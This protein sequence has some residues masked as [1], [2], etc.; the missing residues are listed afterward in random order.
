MS[1]EY[2]PQL[3]TSEDVFTVQFP[4]TKFRDG[5]DQ[6]QIDDY[7]DEVVRVLSYY[8]ALNASP[9]AEV[10]LAYI[11]VRGVDVREVDFDY[12]RMRVG[13]DQDAVDD[14]LDQV[15]ATLE[16]Y[17]RAYGIPP[18]DQHYQ[19]LQVDGPA[20]EAEAAQQAAASGELP[21]DAQGAQD[22]QAADKTGDTPQITAGDDNTSAQYQTGYDSNALT[23]SATETGKLFPSVS[24]Y[25]SEPNNY[26]AS[27]DS[28]TEPRND[29]PEYSS[30][31]GTP[32][33]HPEAAGKTENNLVNA[34][35]TTPAPNPVGAGLAGEANPE[36]SET[37]P[38]NP[39]TP[40]NATGYNGTQAY[41]GYDQEYDTGYEPDSEP[42]SE[43]GDYAEQPQDETEYVNEDESDTGA[44]TDTE[45]PVEY[46]GETSPGSPGST[47]NP[48]AYAGNNTDSAGSDNYAYASESNQ[49]NPSQPQNEPDA[50]LSEA[51]LD[52]P[53][54]IDLTDETGETGETPQ[55]YPEYQNYSGYQPAETPQDAPGQS[56]ATGAE[57]ASPLGTMTP[58]AETPLATGGSEDSANPL[59]DAPAAPSAG[60]YPNYAEAP[61]TPYAAPADFTN[62]APAG[63][64][65]QSN[66][67]A[68]STEY[69]GMPPY[70]YD[71][72]LAYGY[73]QQSWNQSVDYSQYPGQAPYQPNGQETQ[74]AWEQIPAS[75]PNGETQTDNAWGN[76]PEN[77]DYAGTADSSGQGAY[78]GYPGQM[79]QP[80]ANGMP[81]QASGTP[82]TA[83]PSP[84]ANPDQPSGMPETGVPAGN[85]APAAGQDTTLDYGNTGG[86][87]A[88][89]TPV[90]YLSYPSYPATA[91]NSEYP[92]GTGEAGGNATPGF[93]QTPAVSSQ[94]L[95]STAVP[96]EA[97]GVPE[98]MPASGL[99]ADAFRASQNPLAGSPAATSTTGSLPATGMEPAQY[100]AD[101]GMPTQAY[102]YQ[103]VA[104]PGQAQSTNGF[105]AEIPADSGYTVPA[106]T[107]ATGEYPAAV[108]S[109]PPTAGE[110]P[111]NNPTAPKTAPG[112]NPGGIASPSGA[113]LTSVGTVGSVSSAGAASVGAAAQGITPEPGSAPVASAPGS[114]AGS[115]PGVQSASR[116]APLT[117]V[118]TPELPTPGVGIDLSN[119]GYANDSARFTEAGETP[120]SPEWEPETS[121]TA[122][123]G[124]T[125]GIP[126]ASAIEALNQASREPGIGLASLTNTV[127]SAN[128]ASAAGSSR[129]R[130]TEIP[131]GSRAAERAKTPTLGEADLPGDNRGADTGL[132]GQTG[133]TEFP[134]GNLPSEKPSPASSPKLTPPAVF[135]RET[136]GLDPLQPQS[137]SST[138]GSL[139]KNT[140]LTFTEVPIDHE[141][142][143]LMAQAG[144]NSEENPAEVRENAS[145]GTRENVGL[146]DNSPRLSP[147]AQESAQGDA[148][149]KTEKTQEKTQSPSE[150]RN[151]LPANAN[152]RPLLQGE[153]PFGE[154]TEEGRFVP[155]FL[156]GYRTNLDTFTSAYG[157]LEERLEQRP[158]K[159]ESIAKLEA[160]QPR[161]S[162]T[163]AYLVTVTTSR[164]LGSDDS[165]LVRFP[166]G[167]EVPVTSA[168]S[169]FN[170]VHLNI[171]RL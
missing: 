2:T 76:N 59:P 50:S 49:P 6:N 52:L 16:A 120:I 10:N 96:A 24:A 142:A 128:Q 34:S 56:L 25:G 144:A 63:Y 80:Q 19:V 74:A 40:S 143:S 117:N 116:R 15:A 110:N 51:E 114:F 30:V 165:V 151:K 86:N 141:E 159:A 152:P 31:L 28:E 46:P 89:N 98:G 22:V 123:G 57:A 148:Q 12:T 82:E 93:T 108:P 58:T 33:A 150:N 26:P 60:A 47:L 55:N 106:E 109:I 71:P 62:G 104:Y 118:V 171:P 136:P 99:P 14:Y 119:T 13:Y 88:E 167:R 107:P 72:N 170:G 135:T 138:G 92:G 122:Q 154:V 97:T 140:G 160:E 127:A 94:P 126:A 125:P 8:E 64:D 5:Y 130:L 21:Q 44:D 139:A 153:E 137:L 84:P 20:L 66:T 54:E 162:I 7:L 18:S 145:S 1:E 43:Y 90:S 91:Q 112:T 115:E 157:S 78:P 11:T 75:P 156:A 83:W 70:G 38:Q 147:S 37:Y 164:P 132:T 100:P 168:Y 27:P 166:D 146:S 77:W 101:R 32:P 124:E 45:M 113:G 29:A 103:G 169:D 155:H 161:K 35:Q 121:G 61:E 134:P 158:K 81:G 149:E 85:P 67:A 105:S 39:G 111:G 131:L 79:T 87:V 163:T 95:D 41:P 36:N 102:G 48:A 9:E 133:A 42:D 17:E 73:P 53:D 23:E 129:R 65:Y 4:A 3:L 69:A 68:E